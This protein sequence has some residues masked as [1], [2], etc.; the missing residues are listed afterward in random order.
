MLAFWPTKERY[1][2]I[3]GF[4]FWDEP[5][6]YKLTECN[7]HMWWMGVFLLVSCFFE[8][9]WFT[10]SL[11]NDLPIFLTKRITKY[12]ADNLGKKLLIHN[13]INHYMQNISI[14]FFN[15]PNYP[16][17]LKVFGDLYVR[18]IKNKPLVDITE[19]IT[20]EDIYKFILPDLGIY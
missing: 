11:L 18:V 9:E 20:S 12:H 13:L 16:W 10:T 17:K 5:T 15:L 7:Q 14:L 6:S 1:F 19:V 2:L 4:R 8:A 3:W